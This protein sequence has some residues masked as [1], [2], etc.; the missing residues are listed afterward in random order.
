M[1]LVKK[2]LGHKHVENTIEH[3]GGYISKTNEFGVAAT[4][5]LDEDKRFISV[6]FQFVTE[7]NGVK[8]WCARNGLAVHSKI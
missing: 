1:L 4:T 2:L 7:R 6:G 5:T 3:L 8:L